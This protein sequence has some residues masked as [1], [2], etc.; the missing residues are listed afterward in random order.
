MRSLPT[1]KA[2]NRRRMR[3]PD[4]SLSSIIS[5]PQEIPR[6][7]LPP[8][9]YAP[10]AIANPQGTDWTSCMND[11]PLTYKDAGVD[12]DAGNELVERIKPLVSKTRRLEV[13]SGLGGFGGLFAL[14]PGKYAQPV[15][16]SGTDGVGTK[17]KPARSY[18]PSAYMSG[19]S[20]VSPPI[21]A[22]PACWHPSAIPETTFAAISI[23]S[24]PQAK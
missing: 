5:T 4:S 21:K 17:L 7:N 19:I 8:P 18:S 23:S 16:V 22:A 10:P 13:L 20:A 15:L 3:F 9:A 24:L 11:K 6:N 12:I 14:E 1:I 2:D